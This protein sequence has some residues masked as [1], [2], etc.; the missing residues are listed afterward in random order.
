MP[1]FVWVSL[2]DLVDGDA[3]LLGDICAEFV[4]FLCRRLS[5]GK[6]GWVGWRGRRGVRAKLCARGGGGGGPLLTGNVRVFSFD[7][8]THLSFRLYWCHLA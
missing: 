5:E 2:E 4:Q 7:L 6:R 3:V 8:S 1:E